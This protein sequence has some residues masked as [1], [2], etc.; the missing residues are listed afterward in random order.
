MKNMTLTVKFSI[1]FYVFMFIII[2][3]NGLNVFII[4]VNDYKY[5]VEQNLKN[6]SA[7]LSN[8]IEVEGQRFVYMQDFILNNISKFKIPST[9][10]GAYRKELE[11]FDREFVKTYP[12]KVFEVDIHFDDLSYELKFL[13]TEFMF[14]KWLNIFE[15][16]KEKFNIKYAYY[17]VPSK[18]QLHMYW[19][20]D[21]HRG[22][23]KFH[24]PD[25]INICADVYEPIEEHKKMWEAWETGLSPKGYDVYDNKYGKTYAYYTPLFIG[26]RKCGVIGVEIEIDR[27]RSDIL[28]TVV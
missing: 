3:I 24:G 23:S 5:Q 21:F 11:V 7:F 6:I 13:Y 12:G 14:R 28:S 27:I 17:L 1:V 15:K 18:E 10:D 22:I 9:F 26:D 2:L 25:F 8:M 4:Q 16:A 20:L 19:L